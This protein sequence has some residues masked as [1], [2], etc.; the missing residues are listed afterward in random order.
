MIDH[1]SFQRQ[2]ISALRAPATSET[3][4]ESEI[5]WIFRLLPL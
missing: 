4:R 2:D 5:L 3:K 1:L